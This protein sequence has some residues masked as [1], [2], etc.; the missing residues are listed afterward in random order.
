MIKKISRIPFAVIIIICLGLL[1]PGLPVNYFMIT[2]Q[3]KLV[4]AAP[5][6]NAA[7]FS[8]SYI[9]SV[10]LTPVIDDYRISGGRIWSWEERVMSHNAG[11]P[12]EAP[13]HGRF[14]V[15]SPWLIVQGGR[16]DFGVI[17]YRVGND[18]FGR[19]TW[20]IPPFQE[21]E[22]YEKYPSQRVFISSEIRKLKDAEV[23]GLVGFD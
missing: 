12:F 11:L 5:M 15:D 14:I 2:A 8:S 3:G 13:E 17:A 1:Y 23:A 20:R 21:I 10:Q 18:K 6:P 4:L 19:N 9:H 22:A 16:Q 7:S